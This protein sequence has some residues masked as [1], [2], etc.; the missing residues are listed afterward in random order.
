MA[1]LSD[2]RTARVNAPRASVRVESTGLPPPSIETWC[3]TTQAPT[4]GRS[5][6]PPRSTRPETTSPCAAKSALPR[7]TKAVRTAKAARLCATLPPLPSLP[8]VPLRRELPEVFRIEVLQVGLQRIRV[9]RLTGRQPS[10]PSR[11]R[12]TALPRLDGGEPEQVL[13]RDDGGLEAQRHGDG[14]RGAGVDLDHG[15]APIDVQLG[16]VRVVLHLGDDDLARSE[17]HTSELQSHSDL[18]CRLLLE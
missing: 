16:V 1:V 18:V 9:E 11:A 13:A 3:I 12:L 8:P 5:A 15:V 6:A 10:W 14:V 4:S 17:E 2:R 7:P